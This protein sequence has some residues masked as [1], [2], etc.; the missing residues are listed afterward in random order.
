LLQAVC[1]EGPADGDFRP[2]VEALSFLSGNRGSDSMDAIAEEVRRIISRELKI[3][4]ER[5]TPDAALKD[6]GIESLGLIEIIFALEDKF[7]IRIPYNANEAAG[8]EGKF[9]MAGLGKLETVAELCAAVK[10][11]V[12]AKTVA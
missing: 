10:S 12:A 1:R 7:D 3:P 8:G 11:L 5:L 2:A 9:E 4:P 6:L